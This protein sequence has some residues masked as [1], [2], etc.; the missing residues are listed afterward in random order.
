[1][2]PRILRFAVVLGLAVFATWVTTGCGSSARSK[3]IKSTFV[4]VNALRDGFIDWDMH[5]QE[6]IVDQAKTFDEGRAEL[7]RY[8]RN[9]EPIVEGFEGVYRALAA[10]TLV[11]ND[12][13]NLA[14][15]LAA[16]KQLEDAIAKFKKLEEAPHE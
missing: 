16:A 14:H 2:T 11:S 12:P 15:L 9:R 13:A 1:V 7:L 4:S 8:R 3:M 6:R 5:R 10:A